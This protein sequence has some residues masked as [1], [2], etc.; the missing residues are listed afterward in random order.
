MKKLKIYVRN[1]LI[2][3]SVLSLAYLFFFVPHHGQASTSLPLVSGNY[4]IVQKFLHGDA[5]VLIIGDSIQNGIIDF[6]PKVWKID[7]WAGI[8][9]SPGMDANFAGDPGVAGFYSFPAPLYSVTRVESGDPSVDPTNIPSDI[10]P[11]PVHQAV[12]SATPTIAFNGTTLT[13]RVYSHSLVDSMYSYYGGASWIAS[14]TPL[15][16]DILYYANPTG[17][18]NINVVARGASA[19]VPLSTTVFSAYSTTSMLK[20][21]PFNFTA[22]VWSP[23]VNTNLDFKFPD[24]GYT[25]ASSTNLAIIGTHFYTGQPGFQYANISRGGKAVDYFMSAANGSAANLATFLNWEDTNIVYIWLGQ[26]SGTDDAATYETKMRALIA[27]YKAAKPGIQFVLVSTYDTGNTVILGGQAQALYNISQSDRDVVFLN[28]YQSAGNFATLDATYLADHVHPN[29][30][31]GTTY[32]A[33]QTETLLELAQVPLAAAVTNPT[34]G[35]T[36]SGSNIIITATTTSNTG[37]IAGVQLKLDGAT[38]IGAEGTTTPYSVVWN[39]TGVVNGTHTIVA[40]ARDV[41]GNY[42]TSSPITITVNNVKRK[43]H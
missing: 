32:F 40:V 35:S 13:N 43:P 19:S 9:A 24:D 42:A 15:H 38:P 39:S 25:P 10:S 8:T 1:C 16:A 6:Y 33:N 31:V 34:T 30:P 27:R 20:I 14:G 22:N 29:S 23:G 28:L 37:T 41:S 12:F 5:H 2:S 4:K 17:A 18:A 36:V 3:A 21:L 26:N 7:K 11:G